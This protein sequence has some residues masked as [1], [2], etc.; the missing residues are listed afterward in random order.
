MKLQPL[1]LALG[2]SLS[3]VN[4]QA[5]VDAGLPVYQK[6]TGYFG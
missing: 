4:A 3:V 1:V 2:L 6:T 5:A